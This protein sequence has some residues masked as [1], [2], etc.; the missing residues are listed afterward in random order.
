MDETR[1]PTVRNVAA[2]AGVSHQT[3]SRVINNHPSV[4]AATRERVSDAIGELGYRPNPAARALG[5][6]RS[7][8]PPAND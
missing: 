4:S 2:R 7:S 5:Q 1:A 6:R 3:V 8:A